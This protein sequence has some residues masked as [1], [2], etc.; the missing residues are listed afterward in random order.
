MK[1]GQLHQILQP[2][3]LEIQK[4]LI[5]LGAPAT[6]AE[7]I[8]QDTV[9]KALLYIDSID[10]NKFS[11][12]LY[13]VAINR[14]YDLCRRSKRIIIPIDYVDVP[15]TELPE[16]H[17]LLKEKREDIDRVLAE[18]QPLHKQLIIM[19]Y[20][21]ELSYQEIA[22]L[23]GITTDTVKSALFRARKQFQKKYRG[24]AE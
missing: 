16:D 4:Y 12:W 5:R 13:K 20:E 22:E 8:V 23:L 24:E 18:L 3:M 21:L 9:Y 10:E 11:A 14:Y 1:P 2:K 19:K 15:D 6:D 17:L 7:D